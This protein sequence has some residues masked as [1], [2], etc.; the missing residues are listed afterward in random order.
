[1]EKSNEFHNLGPTYKRITSHTILGSEAGVAEEQR[2]L[3]GWETVVMFIM[4]TKKLAADE[5]DTS[6]PA[7]NQFRS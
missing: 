5:T 6:Q 3:D 4:Q 7:C 1:M 2:C